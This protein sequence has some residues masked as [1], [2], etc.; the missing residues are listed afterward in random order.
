MPEA[1]DALAAEPEVYRLALVTGNLEPVARRKLASAGLGGYFAAGQG[2]FGSDA[3]DR[4]AAARDRARA[5]RRLG[6][7]RAPW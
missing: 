7:R 6:A 3:E 4:G 1:L 2:G 5:G